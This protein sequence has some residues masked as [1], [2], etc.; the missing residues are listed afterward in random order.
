MRI[1]AKAGMG[2]E[3]WRIGRVEERGAGWRRV[4]EGVGGR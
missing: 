1:G 4:S 2:G 3:G